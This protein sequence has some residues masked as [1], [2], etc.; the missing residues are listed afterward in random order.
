M[1]KAKGT[2]RDS[3]VPS[4]FSGPRTDVPAEP[5]SHRHCLQHQVEF[6]TCIL[7]RAYFMS[8]VIF[9]W[10]AMPDIILN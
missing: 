3:W 5:P 4:W 9:E 2:F 1:A 10:S 7:K 6:T 8:V